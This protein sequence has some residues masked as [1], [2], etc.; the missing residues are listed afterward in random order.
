MLYHIE[1]GSSLL[2]VVVMRKLQNILEHAERQCKTHGTRLTAKRKQILSSLLQRG[3][4][5][6]AY[7]VIDFYKSKF[8]ETIPAMSVYRIL[9]FLQNENLVHKLTSANKYVACAH[10]TCQNTHALSQFLICE[11][12]LKVKEVSINH[13]MSVALKK[14]VKRAGF[15]LVSPQLEINCICDTCVR[16]A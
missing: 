7:E 14:N 4:A 13:A 8:G 6:S 2:K 9:D 11:K 15:Q 16:E 12:C 3:R 1:M 5:M 10:I